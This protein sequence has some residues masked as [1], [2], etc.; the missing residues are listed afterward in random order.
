MSEQKHVHVLN[1]LYAHPIARNIEWSELI[2]AL[3]TIGLLQTEK[4]GNYHLTRNGKTLVFDASRGKEVD[5]EEVLK[6]RH[7]LRLSAVPEDGNLDLVRDAIVAIDHHQATIY[8]DPG[9]ESEQRTRLYA[10]LTKGR[11]L[12]THPTSP[13]FHEASPMMDGDYYESV[14][15]E[16]AKSKRIV[17]LSHG[18]GTSSSASQL[19][20]LM[21]KKDPEIAH[22]IVAVRACDLEAMTEPQLVKLGTEALRGVT[23]G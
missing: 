19:L 9:T 1:Q 4:N 18:T 13:P 6:L 7:F 22:R 10:N 2:P 23:V 8:H 21:S 14:V 3:S 20:A 11:I 12:R 17:I 15:K 16:I 5:M